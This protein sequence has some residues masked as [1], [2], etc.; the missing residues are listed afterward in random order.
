MST[1]LPTA[2]RPPEPPDLCATAGVL[3]IA[4]AAWFAWSLAGNELPAAV[5]VVAAALSIC[6]GIT[7]FALRRRVGGASVHTGNPAAY[8]TYNRALLFEVA[9][10]VLGNLALGRLGLGEYIPAWTMAMMGLHFPPLARLYRI[11]A[12]RVLAVVVV[13]LSVIGVLA[14]LTEWAMPATVCCGLGG[15]AMVITAVWSIHAATRQSSRRVTDERDV[16]NR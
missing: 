13:A 3:G 2:V 14:G 9:A 1:S 7:G 8:R 15:L 4:A 10:I 5:M 12:L 6:V 16:V 11:G